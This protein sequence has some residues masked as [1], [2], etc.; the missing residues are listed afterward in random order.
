MEHFLC[1]VSGTYSGYCW[2]MPPLISEDL[3]RFEA[4]DIQTPSSANN[5]YR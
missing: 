1:F 5:H 2:P 4:T 3:S